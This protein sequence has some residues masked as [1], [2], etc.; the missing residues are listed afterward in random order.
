MNGR[1]M[2]KLA[3]RI[4]GLEHAPMPPKK[5]G[6][7]LRRAARPERIR[8]TLE[9][10]LN[11]FGM[12]AWAWRKGELRVGSIG[13]WAVAMF[14][15]KRDRAAAAASPIG[16]FETARRLLGL[17][18]HFAMHLLTAPDRDRAGFTPEMAARAIRLT[19]QDAD[20]TLIWGQDMDE[21]EIL[22]RSA[23]GHNPFRP[24]PR[25]HYAAEIADDEKAA[26]RRRRRETRQTRPH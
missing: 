3:K 21:A 4:Q 20:P 23:G 15:R 7:R 12:E 26:R 6:R 13:A 8:Q 25:E 16:L 22:E 10:G 9:G 17:D 1:R 18:E 5:R 11:A 24:T 14:G 2:E 19:I